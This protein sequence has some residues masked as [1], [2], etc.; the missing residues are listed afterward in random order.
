MVALKVNLL[1]YKFD[2]QKLFQVN[3]D[4]LCAQVNKVT[5][6]HLS[7]DTNN[8]VLVLFAYVHEATLHKYGCDFH[9]AL[10][11]LC[12]Q[13]K[14][15]H[16]HTNVSLTNIVGQ[17][18]VADSICNPADAPAPKSTHSVSKSINML[19]NFVESFGPGSDYNKVALG[20]S[21]VLTAN[22]PVAPKNLPNM[23]TLH[24]TIQSVQ[25]SWI[26]QI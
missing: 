3:M 25:W 26:K 17:L 13:Y 19:S 10:H 16:Q 8:Y 1:Q 23:T 5:L 7:F 6:Y 22:L 20:V 12:Q 11:I 24:A 14:F 9:E 2:W 4:Q 15:N 21:L 18:T